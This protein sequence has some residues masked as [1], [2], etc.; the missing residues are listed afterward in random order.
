MFALIGNTIK[1]SSLVLLVLV[2]SH[3]IQIRGV[4]ISKHVERTMSW[5]ASAPQQVTRVTQ[6]F[7]SGVSHQMDSVI[8]L[9]S[10][11]VERDPSSDI[12]PSDQRE[13]KQLIERQQRR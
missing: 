2:L 6:E 10:S 4:S 7:S 13:L 1:Y 3:V 8:R 11:K 5:F 9:R 12:S